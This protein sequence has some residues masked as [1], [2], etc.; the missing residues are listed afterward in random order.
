MNAD[1]THPLL[2]QLLGQVGAILAGDSGDE[3][4]LRHWTQGVMTVRV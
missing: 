4:S 3:G 1:H 2:E